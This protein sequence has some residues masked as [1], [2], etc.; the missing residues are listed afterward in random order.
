MAYRAYLNANQ[1]LT[2]VNQGS[3]TLISLVTNRPGQQQ[4]QNNSFTTGQWN[5]PPQLFQM[6]GGFILQIDGDRQ[7]HLVSIQANSI[8]TLTSAPSLE[9]AVKINLDNIPD[10]PPPEYDMD[11]EPMQP[12]QPMWMGNM[13]M[14]M[15]PMSVRMGNMSIDIGEGRTSTSGKRF[16][17]QCGQA[18]KASDR[19]CCN[20][21]HQ[22]NN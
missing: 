22:L 8:S 12:M 6:A 20:C 14:S 16:C 3:Q 2:I 17:T 4:S 19:F 5:R 1:Q 10:P 11:F 7:R 13:S 18:A 21:G 15:N 9:N